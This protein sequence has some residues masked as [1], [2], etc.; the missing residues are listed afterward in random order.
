MQVLIDTNVLLDI[1]FEKGGFYK[2][3]Y[4][5]LLRLVTNNAK[6]YITSSCITDIYYVLNKYGSKEEAKKRVLSLINLCSVL[7][8]SEKE[9]C[10]ALESEVNDYEDAIVEACAYI[11]KCDFILTRNLKDFKK[12]KVSAVS[13]SDI[14]DK[15]QINT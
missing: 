14:N 11:N 13:P 15:Y 3:S 4:G 8:I 12:S 7:P 9:I 6:C 5:A 1:C 2:S 10:L